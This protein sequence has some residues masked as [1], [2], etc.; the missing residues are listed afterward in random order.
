MT[1]P[2]RIG[3][4]GAAKIA[5]AA[6][7]LP[8]R[9]NKDFTVVAVA[10]RDR[11]RA[12]VYA[13]EYGIPEVVSDYDAL[14]THPDVDL[15]YNPLPPAFHVRWTLATLEAGKPVLCEKPFAMNADEARTMVAAAGRAG[16]SLIEAFHYRYHA[17]MKRAVEIARSGELGRLTE[18]E[19]MFQFPMPYR[20]DELRWIAPVGGGALMDMGCYPL[21]ALRSAIGG[22]PR[23]VSASCEVQ[24]GVDA[25]TKAELLFPDDIKAKM[26]C[27]MIPESFG[28][29]LHLTGERGRLEIVNF[30]APQY[31]FSF[32]VT[33]DG[34][35]REEKPEGPATYAAQLAAVADVLRN[36]TKPLTGGADAV[37]NMA[38][39][40][41]IYAK[42]GYARGG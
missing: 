10:A 22:E 4:L 25:A 21:H 13:K 35:T 38:A 36:G 31:G 42:A 9:D 18:A 33:V 30:L 5:P 19:A 39:I 40:D 8:A 3:I 14:V 23:I 27:S 32:K 28:A 24:H 20:A 29:F 7:I 16:L 41:A 26:S 15:I 12:E 34:K 2:I 6:V 11:S 37:A 1:T 17:V